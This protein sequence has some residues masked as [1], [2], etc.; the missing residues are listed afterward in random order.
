MMYALHT[1]AALAAVLSLAVLGRAAARLLRQPE[2]V[3]EVVAGLLAG[4]AALALLDRDGFDALLPGP[5]LGA[6][7]L[8]AEAAL[9]LFLVGL[10]HE[11]GVAGRAD[12][13]GSAPGGVPDRTTAGLRRGGPGQEHPTGTR[14]DASRVTRRAAAW[15]A[16]GGL[17]LPLV[18]GGLLT[19]WVVAYGDPA[20]R[21]D[22]PL[23]AFTL[24][25]AVA[26]SV[27]AVPVLAR[28]LTDR[29]MESTRAGRLALGA[30][31]V[32][33]AV[34]W[35]LLTAALALA[36][37]SATGILNAGGALAVGVLCALG[38][39]YGLRAHVSLLLLRRAPAVAA[40][41]IAATALVTAFT[42]EHLGMTAILGAA[43]VGLAIPGD[44]SASWAPAVSRV[45]GAGR[46]LVPSF[47]V[48]AG[49][50][51]LAQTSV[52]VSWTLIGLVLVLGVLGKVLG[53][54]AGTRLA[55][56]SRREAAQVGVLLNTRGL[57]ELIIIQ[58]GFTA[59]LLTAPLLLALIVMTLVTTAATGPLLR[60][61]DRTATRAPSPDPTTA[62]PAPSPDPTTATAVPVPL[63]TE[64]G[65][66]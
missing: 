55:G 45:A 42:M 13:T 1:A 28:I 50:T 32:I 48:V 36:S 27:T 46:A 6:L 25:L 2:V 4:P 11:L 63:S 54:Y 30:A 31:L 5:V 39:R 10:A 41:L 19:G 49:V 7:K 9:V 62:T 8:V 58:V 3:G 20:V 23:P 15:V 16:A 53:G 44:R 21:G 64:S 59:G 38:V 33:D 52:A 57:T 17:L 56:G 34:G 65:V 37:G 26:L 47:F 40:C 29:G 35:L 66:R 12:G 43:M 51:V 22:A 14:A 24:M 60:L 18:T 61:L